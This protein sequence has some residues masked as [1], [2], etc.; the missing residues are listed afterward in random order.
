[1]IL[2]KTTRIDEFMSKDTGDNE[3]EKNVLLSKY[4]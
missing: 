3:N 2:E 4:A 1:M